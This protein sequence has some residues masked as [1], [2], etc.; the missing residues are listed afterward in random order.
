MAAGQQRKCRLN[1]MI[2]QYMFRVQSLRNLRA[3]AKIS[4][5]QTIETN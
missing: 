3:A 4:Y 1:I 5:R 2:G